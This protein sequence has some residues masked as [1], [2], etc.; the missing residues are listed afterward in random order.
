MP[1][2]ERFAGDNVWIMFCRNV[3]LSISRTLAHIELL[4]I[5]RIYGS[6]SWGRDQ[7]RPFGGRRT[8]ENGAK[9]HQH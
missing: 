3:D 4:L 5:S 1:L 6:L 2:P 8:H 7:D 9:T